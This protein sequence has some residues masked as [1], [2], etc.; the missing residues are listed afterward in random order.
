MEKHIASLTAAQRQLG[1]RVTEVYNRG[2]PVGESVQVWRP[3]SIGQFRPYFLRELLFY[4]AALQKRFDFCDRRLRVVHIHGDW[5]SFLFGSIF[6]R[7]IGADAVAAS[8]HEW[9]RGSPRSYA[10]AL[11]SCDPIFATGLAEAGYLGKVTGRAAIH[12][13]SAPSDMFFAKPKSLAPPCDVVVVGSLVARKRL[14]LVLDL[15]ELRPNLRI[16][17]FGDGPERARLERLRTAKGLKLVQFRGNAQPEEIHSSLHTA[18]LFL[19]VA[20]E[21]GSPTAALEAMACGRPVVMTPS[22]DYSDLVEQGVNG[23][24]T[25]GWDAEEIATAIDLF[26]G[27]PAMLSA[28]GAAAR[29]TAE[30]HRWR[31]KARIVTDAM[32]RALQAKKR[33]ACG[34]L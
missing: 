28:A 15:A 27:N 31:Q 32:I 22:N 21:E 9:A 17:I 12:L 6:A 23:W 34:G 29:R 30:N 5:P 8:L 20:T 7:A 18:G 1:I 19:N 26:L 33:Q 25:S 16:S 3:S 14:D 10:L 24:V 4:S 2:N 13:P 11:R